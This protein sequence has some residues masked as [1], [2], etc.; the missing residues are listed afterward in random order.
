[1][2][3]HIKNYMTETP[4]AIEPSQTLSVVK[5]KMN[6]FKFRHLPVREAGAIVGVISHNDL[7]LAEGLPGID[8]NKTTA[9]D[10][11]IQDVYKTTPETHLNVVCKEMESRKIGSALVIDED[12]TLVGIFTVTDALHLLNK[13][14][15]Q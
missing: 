12:E 14:Y 2:E 8:F 13:I 5:R 3:A 1:M 6:E 4:H 11:M 9:E 7:L 10:V 15:A